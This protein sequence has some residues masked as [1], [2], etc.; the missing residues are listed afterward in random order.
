MSTSR[1][2][3]SIEFT[4]MPRDQLLAALSQWDYIKRSDPFM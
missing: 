1:N 4:V 3:A 2:A